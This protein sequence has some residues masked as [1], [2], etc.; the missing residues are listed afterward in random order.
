MNT[1]SLNNLW[2]YLQ[3]L[4]LTASNQ[5]WLA[6]HL[7]EAVRK[8]EVEVR[9]QK[10]LQLTKEDLILSPD[11]LEPIKDITPLPAD[12]DLSKARTDYLMQKY[13]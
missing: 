2:I 8:K 9:K 13:G 10:K 3:S 5:S 4:N 7:N 6:E 11:I 1:V 12:F